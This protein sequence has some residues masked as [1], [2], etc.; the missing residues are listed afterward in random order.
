MAARGKKAGGQSVGTNFSQ[1]SFTLR[2]K[3][4]VRGRQ[5]GSAY[6]CPIIC[7][8]KDS[9]QGRC[10]H[11]VEEGAAGAGTGQTDSRTPKSSRRARTAVSPAP[12]RKPGTGRGLA[13]W[14]VNCILLLGG[15]SHAGMCSSH[16]HLANAFGASAHP[17]CIPGLLEDLLHRHLGSLSLSFIKSPRPGGA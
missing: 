14:R 17:K 16:K 7:R 5:S 4:S 15:I 1:K 6:T 13:A 10:S 9:G 8:W 12:N 11:V 2:P 3:S